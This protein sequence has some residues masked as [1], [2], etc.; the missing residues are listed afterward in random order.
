MSRS[1]AAPTRPDAIDLE[2]LDSAAAFVRAHDTDTVLSAMLPALTA[3]ERA[4]IAAR[5]RFSHAAV[6]IFPRDMTE[7]SAALADRG[8]SAGPATPSVVVRARLAARYGRPADQLD[9]RIVRAS[10][11]S[12]DGHPCTIEIFALLPAPGTSTIDISAAE[13]NAGHEQHLALDI[14]T[15]DPVELTG[16][17]TLLLRQGLMHSDGGGYNNHE[18]TSILYFHATGTDLPYRRLEFHVA[19]HHPQILAAHIAESADAPTRLLRLLTGA[20]A[21][22]A[23]ATAATLNVADQLAAAPGRT[24]AELAALTGTDPDSLH[25]LLRYLAELDI[26]RP[27]GDGYELTDTGALLPASAAPSLHPL[28]RLYGGAFYQ[29][30]AHLDHAVRTGRAGFD[31]HFGQHH[32]EHFSATP[33]DAELFDAAM[34]AGATIFGQVS[35]LIDLTTT[36]TIIDVAGGN[37]T[38]LAHLLRSAPHARGVLFERAAT[39]PAARRVLDRIGCLHRC[40]LVPGDFTTEVP[41]GGDIYLLSRVLHDWDDEQCDHILRRCAEAMPAHATLYIIERLLPEDRTPSLAPAWDVHMLCNVGGRERT[42]TH[43][44]ELLATAGLA[45]RETQQ[46]PLDF[47]LLRAVHELDRPLVRRPERS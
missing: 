43:Y 33:E 4:A 32:F 26:V 8:L 21:T 47:T 30:F 7:L 41:E 46:L 3:A 18:N 44:R 25:R 1:L 2:H 10:V 37:G 39:L 6:L 35:E 38:L 23:L 29:S 19:G 45:L 22:Q 9:V 11:S 5:C 12:A 17:R 20:W 15:G 28:A 27:R 16:L 40:R 24:V 31:H 34:A 13:R 36:D 14:E 42:R